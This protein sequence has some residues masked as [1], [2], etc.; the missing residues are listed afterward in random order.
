MIVTVITM[1]IAVFFLI[2]KVNPNIVLV[3]MMNINTALNCIYVYTYTYIYIYDIR[4]YIYKGINIKKLF[5]SILFF[6]NIVV[7]VLIVLSI[8]DISLLVYC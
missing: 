3:P 5:I 7:Y 2:I 1:M 6:N 8:C 4:V